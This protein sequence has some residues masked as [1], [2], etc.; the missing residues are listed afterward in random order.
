MEKYSCAYRT[1]GPFFHP[2][3]E[4]AARP[5]SAVL[6]DRRLRSGTSAALPGKGI[7]GRTYML[8]YQRHYLP[9]HDS[10]RLAK[11]DGDVPA[12]QGIQSNAAVT[13]RRQLGRSGRRRYANH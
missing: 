12:M 4:A 6:G 11:E 3:E 13:L 9:G 1:S 7:S 8:V 2:Y 10:G 5:V